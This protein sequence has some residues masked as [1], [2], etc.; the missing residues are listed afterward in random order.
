MR[1]HKRILD[2]VAPADIV[3]KI[4]SIRIDPSVDVEISVA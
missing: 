4:T 1:I 3:R 2:V